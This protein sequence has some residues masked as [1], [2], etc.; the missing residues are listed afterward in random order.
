MYLDLLGFWGFCSS[1]E[2]T[3]VSWRGKYFLVEKILINDRIL[4]DSFL[5][6][7]LLIR[8]QDISMYRH[9]WRSS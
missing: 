7:I 8:V 1:V 4:W 9:S 2:L 6:E 3:F 5:V